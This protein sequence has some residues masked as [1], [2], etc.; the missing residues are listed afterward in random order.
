MTT[1]EWRRETPTVQSTDAILPGFH[2]GQSD[3]I[4]K[5]T[6]IAYRKQIVDID[7]YLGLLERQC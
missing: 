5:V 4:V 3:A 1:P 6:I 7:D 2:I